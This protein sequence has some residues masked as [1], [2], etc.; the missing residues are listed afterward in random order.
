MPKTIATI[1]GIVI[2]VFAGVMFFSNSSTQKNVDELTGS[3]YTESITEDVTWS[4]DYTF[5][6]GR[7]TSLIKQNNGAD[8]R[9]DE[10]PYKVISR[11]DDGSMVVM[12]TSD[13]FDKSY[14]V[15]IV[16]MEDGNSLLL[17]GM[18]MDRVQK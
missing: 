16:I 3:W 12:K 1:V 14:E 5:K 7:Y 18:K 15:G 4:V 2:I 11:H 9:F 10:G 13:V 8:E 17:E 6:D